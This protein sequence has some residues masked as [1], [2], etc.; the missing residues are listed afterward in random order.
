MTDKMHEPGDKIAGRYLIEEFIGEGGM[1]E[2][3]RAHDE[4]LSRKVALKAPKNLSATK[5]FHRSALMSARVN[6][7]NV[8]KTLDY[9]ETNERAY[10]I[11][12]LILGLDLKFVM[13]TFLTRLD[14]YMVAWLLHH[15]SRGM[16]ASHHA[17]V[18]HRDI[19]PSNIMV[20]GGASF[21]EAKITDFGVAKMAEAEIDEAVE[22]GE[23]SIQ[24]SATAVGAIPYMAPEVFDTEPFGPPSKPADIWA[25]GALAYEL[26]TGVKPYGEGLKAIKKIGVAPPT[27]IKGLVSLN[28][29]FEAHI[30]QLEQIIAKCLMKDPSTR[31]TADQLV[32]EC[33]ALCYS[34]APREF[35]AVKRHDNPYWGFIAPQSPSKDVFFHVESVYG[36]GKVAV[37]EIFFFSRHDGAGADRAFPLVRA[38]AVP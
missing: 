25:L 18:F 34:I 8:A 29:Q 23:E 16:A 10:L 20:V 11:E 31:L 38:K 19:K 27:P 3:Y 22:S 1:Q 33:E 17:D 26:L 35:G 37:G 9:V 36:G 12:E 13:T 4:L 14:P 5:R 28:S 32:N 21:I 30:A 2:V 24:A 15:L 6:H 7:A